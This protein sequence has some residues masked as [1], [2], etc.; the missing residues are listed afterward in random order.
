MRSR[1]ARVTKTA[2]ASRKNLKTASC[3]FKELYSAECKKV[4]YP[5]PDHTLTFD[6]LSSVFISIT[7]H[8]EDQLVCL[9]L[10]DPELPIR[11]NLPKYDELA[12][13]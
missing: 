13:R 6:R 10:T 2:A 5:K 4:S 11:D 8:E 7:N 9:K 1:T 12:Q 3:L